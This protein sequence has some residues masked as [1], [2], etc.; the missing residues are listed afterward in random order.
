MACTFTSYGLLVYHYALY[1]WFNGTSATF[2]LSLSLKH[3]KPAFRPKKQVT[4]SVVGGLRQSSSN[5]N[6]WPKPGPVPVVVGQDPPK[7]VQT[8]YW[9][10]TTFEVEQHF[11]IQSTRC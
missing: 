2:S 10:L 11:L 6:C 7:T 4:T 5:P 1:K 9:N 3:V 8:P